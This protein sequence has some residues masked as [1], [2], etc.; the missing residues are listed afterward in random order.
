[1]R[2]DAL[3]IPAFLAVWLQRGSNRELLKRLLPSW[4]F[5]ILLP[6]YIRLLEHYSLWPMTAFVGPLLLLSTVYHPNM[7]I[8][9]IFESQPLRWVGRLSYSLYLWQQLFI[10]HRFIGYKPLGI[11]ETPPFN[12]MLILACAAASFY[13]VEL[14]TMRLGHRLAKP[15]TPVHRDVAVTSSA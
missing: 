12:L 1:M 4:S 7:F 11:L 8:G 3:L 15:A 6:L 13:L 9:R 2:M 5:F 10:C 14:P